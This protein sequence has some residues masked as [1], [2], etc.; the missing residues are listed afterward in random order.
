[1]PKKTVSTG[2][3]LDAT[4]EKLLS[5]GSKSGSVTEDDIQ[6]ALKDVDVTDAQLTSIYRFLR[7]RGVEIVAANED[8]DSELTDDMDES[9]HD[10]DDV[11]DDEE[12]DEDHDLKIA[13][14]A[15]AEMASSKSKKNAPRAHEP[16]PR[17]QPRHGCLH[18]HAHRRSG[19]HVPQRDRQGRPAYRG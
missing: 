8:E 11:L 19:S 3:A 12:S 14:R 18:R 6:V 5:L 2:A 15:D 7:D 13:K 1:M 17:P 4:I 10:D 16:Q 9:V